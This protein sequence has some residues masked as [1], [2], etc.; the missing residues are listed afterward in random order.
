M[1]T[2]RVHTFKSNASIVAL[3]VSALI[4]YPFVSTGFEV[5]AKPGHLRATVRLITREVSL[6]KINPGEVKYSRAISGHQKHIAYTVKTND[7]EFVMV[8][9]IAGKTY[10]SIPRVALSEAGIKEQIRFSPD[11]L[12][13]A[14]VAQRGKKFLVVVDGKEGAEYDRISVGAP[15]F[16]PDSRRVSYFAERGGKTFAVVDGTES[17]PFDYGSSDAPMFSP[18]SRRVIYMARRGKQTSVVIDTAEV[19]ESEYVGGARFSKTGKRMVYTVARGEQWL[20]VTDGKQGKPYSGLGNN[21]EFSE[22]EKRVLYR[23]NTPTGQMIVVDSVETEP[24]PVIEENS[25]GFSPDGQHVAYIGWDS[26]DEQYV[27][28]DNKKGKI[29]EDVNKPIFSPDSKHVVYAAWRAGKMFVVTDGVEGEAFDEV[30]DYVRFSPDG[31]RMLYFAKRGTQQFLVVDGV[32]TAYDEII[33]FKFSPDGKRLFV[34]ARR[35]NSI[36]MALEGGSSKEYEITPLKPGEASERHEFQM[37]FSPD[38][39]RTAWVSQRGGKDF[40]VLDGAEGKP[41]DEIEDL[42]FTAD[43]R[44]LVYAARRD[45]KLVAVVDAIE[46]KAYDEFVEG[47]SLVMDGPRT[48]GMMVM[49]GQEILRV[50][51][52]IAE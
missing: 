35:G 46:S 22:D 19:F 49:R 50:E 44:H 25:Y 16:S 33:D 14:Y 3:A 39:K 40:V 7:G 26:R 5:N 42:Q 23:A 18:D 37:A 28:V 45:G 9:G 43:A 17:K 10:T 12:R 48:I 47:A 31:K 52:E 21:I 13:V 36:L 27:V 15:R 4:A 29:Y 38:S 30:N 41:Y 8:D 1:N 24:R 32:V 20:V 34:E 2:K 11:G 51:I 6:G